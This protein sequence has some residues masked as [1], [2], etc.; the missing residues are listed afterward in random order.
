MTIIHNNLPAT[1]EE[2]IA[3]QTQNVMKA[4]KSTG[5]QFISLNGGKFSMG[6]MTLPDKLPVIVIGW[7]KERQF[8]ESQYNP[9]V[10]SIPACF[11]YQFDEDADTDMAPHEASATPQSSLCK[12]C[13]NDEYGTSQSGRGKACREVRRLAVMSVDSLKSDPR[14]ADIAYLKVPVMSVANWKNYVKDVAA[15]HAGPPWSVVTELSIVR[16]PRSQFKL[17]F[18]AMQSIPKEY[19]AALYAKNQSVLSNMDFAYVLP[20]QPQTPIPAKPV[21]RTRV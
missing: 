3:R 10:A 20:E 9:D 14:T 7:M 2:Q 11:A 1:I 13:P 21:R 15:A 16:D 6:E 8:Y 4:E 5:G 12:G 17:E 19:W 18:N